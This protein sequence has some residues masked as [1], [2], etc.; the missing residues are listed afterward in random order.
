MSNRRLIALVLALTGL[1]LAAPAAQAQDICD[2]YASL[3]QCQGDTGGG[4]GPGGPGGPG[5]GGDDGGGGGAGGGGGFVADLFVADGGDG[6]GGGELPFT[7]YP[8][9]PLV[10][11][12]LVLIATGLLIR[13]GVAVRDRMQPAHASS[14]GRDS[15]SD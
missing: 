9:T 3:P 12:L 1:M 11:V 8:L 2:V 13:L 10:A 4:G 7:G 5:G 15:F 6:G 14:A